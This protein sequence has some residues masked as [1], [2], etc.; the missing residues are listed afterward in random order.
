MPQNGLGLAKNAAFSVLSGIF[1]LHHEEMLNWYSKGTR[2][3]QNSL[4]LVAVALPASVHFHRGCVFPLWDLGIY[5]S[6]EKL[7]LHLTGQ[8][9]FGFSFEFF[10]FFCCSCKPNR[11]KQVSLIWMCLGFKFKTIRPE[12]SCY[13]D[14]CKLL[15]VMM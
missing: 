12:D 3:K 1:F 6:A 10:F 15:E 9:T 7:T 4:C 11:I 2:A 5:N 8:L 13:L 14:S